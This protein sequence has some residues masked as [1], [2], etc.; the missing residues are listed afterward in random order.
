MCRALRAESESVQ[1]TDMGIS[2][3]ITIANSNDSLV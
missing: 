1:F 2:R 3:S